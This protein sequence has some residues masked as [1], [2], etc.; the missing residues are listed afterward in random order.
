MIHLFSGLLSQRRGGQP[1]ARSG[2]RARAVA[3]MVLGASTLFAAQARAG[4]TAIEPS[5]NPGES[6][7]DILSNAYGG[8]FSAQ[9]DGVSYSN[10]TVT[11]TRIDDSQDQT[12]SQGIVSARTLALFAVSP[13][14]TFGYVPGTSGGTFTPLFTAA[15]H[16]AGATGST[17]T[18]VTPS[19][20]YRFAIQAGGQTYTSKD[21]DNTGTLTD[22]AVAY[23]VTGVGAANTNTYVVAFEDSKTAPFDFDNAFEVTAKSA[24]GAGAGGAA[25]P[26]PLAGWAGLSGLL[27]V[28][29]LRRRFKKAR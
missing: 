29:L 15:G 10:G 1:C 25:V 23:K 21:A 24:V 17:S 28:G 8:T 13:S 26:L 22:R 4:F 14:V 18:A 6:Q 3:L 19:G 5:H 9:S 27:G 2:P 20:R 16:G 7:A 12:W 11:A